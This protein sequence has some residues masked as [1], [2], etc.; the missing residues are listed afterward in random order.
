MNR[1]GTVVIGGIMKGAAA[2]ALLQCSG[3]GWC[4]PPV[5]VAIIDTG[6]GATPVLRGQIAASYDM[7][8][9]DRPR[10][11][12]ASPHGTWVAG[13]IA[14]NAK[15][16]FEIISLRVDLPGR[17]I[18]G[19]CVMDRSA[20]GRSVQKALDEHADIIQMSSYGAIPRGVR[21]MFVKA[22]AS[23]TSIVLCAGNQK[24]IALAGQVARE[25][26]AGVY[27][28]G[29]LD[30]KGKISTFSA[31]PFG[32]VDYFAWRIGENVATQ[33]LSGEATTQTGTSFAAAILTAELIDRLSIAR[34]V[35]SPHPIDAGPSPVSTHIR[36]PDVS[37]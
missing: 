19:A 4:S 25:A 15:A 12:L 26:G 31:R 6:V 22:A 35:G 29:S 32:K 8:H 33:G 1:T 30:T 7:L 28:V 16:K 18:G 20:I 36:D 11:A 21:N 13:V 34:S 14:L 10:E 37:D 5:R 17:C 23:G 2:I 24:N 27:V 3:Q 9:P